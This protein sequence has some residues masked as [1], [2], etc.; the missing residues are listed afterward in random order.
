MAAG[1]G[2]VLKARVIAN[3]RVVLDAGIAEHLGGVEHAGIRSD[4]GGAGHGR[5]G[6]FPAATIGMLH[7]PGGRA[8]VA[9]P[10]R[11]SG[12]PEFVV[13]STFLQIRAVGV[14]RLVKAIH[15]IIF[16]CGGDDQEDPVF[17][18]CQRDRAGLVVAEKGGIALSTGIVHDDQRSPPVVARALGEQ[19]LQLHVDHTPGS[20]AGR[21]EFVDGERRLHRRPLLRHLP[22]VRG[23]RSA[24]RLGELFPLLD[25]ADLGLDRLVAGI[26]VIQ[27]AAR[28]VADEVLDV[29]AGQRMF[30]RL[31]DAGFP[32]GHF[33]P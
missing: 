11:G 31:E 26:V 25:A 13:E 19:T 27:A 28:V 5:G 21:R 2:V 23:I 33:P 4:V 3:H 20:A 24:D 12:G 10:G 1:D 9:F 14:S 15:R 8:V 18:R 30:E 6:G 7:Q 32:R 29:G 22:P 16:G 17:I